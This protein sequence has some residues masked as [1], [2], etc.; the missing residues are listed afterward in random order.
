MKTK[1]RFIALAS[2]CLM[3]LPAAA[4]SWQEFNYP[5]MGFAVSFPSA[6]SVTKGSYQTMSGVSL[7][8]TLYAVQQDNVSYR[9]TVADFSGDKKEQAS[10]LSD[11]VKILSRGGE[12]KL[13]VEERVDMNYGHALTIA[14][15]DGSLAN[16]AVFFY[17]SRLYQIEG[18][19]TGANA[20]SVSS[21]LLRFQQSLQFAGTPGLPQRGP[22]PAPEEGGGRGPGPLAGLN[23]QPPP[24]AFVDCRG[25][26]AGDA[27]QHTI[28]TGEVVAATCIVTPQGMAAR[29]DMP[30]DGLPAGRGP[31]G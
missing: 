21:A 28:P 20:D 17:Q 22:G 16:V 3:S 11:A 23:R 27:V 19:A 5:E 30:P 18:R 9:L 4:A 24:Q 6:P 1:I 7:P 14:G 29:P 31:G 2:V 13:D 10:A 26:N 8:A 12:V 25:K 15:K